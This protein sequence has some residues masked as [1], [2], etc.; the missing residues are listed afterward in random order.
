MGQLI[1]DYL[2]GNMKAYIDGVYDYVDVRDVARGIILAGEKDGRGESYILSGEQVSVHQLLSILHEISGIKMPYLK[3]PVWLARITAVF[4][5]F[6]Y[7]LSGKK[8]RFTPYSINVLQSNSDISSAKAKKQLGFSAR[9]VK[10]S[11]ADA[12][13]WFR[14]SGYTTSPLGI[15]PTRLS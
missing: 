12:V 3:I 8:P 4:T 1:I 6:Y 15:Q 10:D 14:E 13:G 5:P 11:I 9:P 2:N 7:R